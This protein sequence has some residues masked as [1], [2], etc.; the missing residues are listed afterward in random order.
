MRSEDRF[1]P[2][3]EVV[4]WTTGLPGSPA[5][6]RDPPALVDLWHDDGCQA[7]HGR[8]DVVH[9]ELHRSLWGWLGIPLAGALRG[10]ERS[11]RVLSC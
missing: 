1:G 2:F 3:E 9:P 10:L 5:A 11:T 4:A 7:Q 6:I 8:A